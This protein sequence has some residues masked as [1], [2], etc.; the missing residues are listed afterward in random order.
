[1]KKTNKITKEEKYTKRYSIMLEIRTKIL[2]W[3]SKIISFPIDYYAKKHNLTKEP[4]VY[5]FK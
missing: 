4:K 1:M 5:D 2:L 3:I